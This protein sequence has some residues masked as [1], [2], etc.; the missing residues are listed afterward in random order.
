MASQ[1]LAVLW[2][3]D[4]THCGGG[5]TPKPTFGPS[6]TIPNPVAHILSPTLAHIRLILSLLP[7]VYPNVWVFETQVHC[8]GFVAS[9]LPASDVRLEQYPIPDR[10]SDMCEFE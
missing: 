8:S 7:R 3:S 4:T 9:T 2:A 10:N 1:N 5:R 6:Y